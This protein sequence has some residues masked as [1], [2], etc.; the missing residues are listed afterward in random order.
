[1]HIV[2]H[3]GSLLVVPLL[4]IAGL[5]VI[6]IVLGPRAGAGRGRMWLGLGILIV[7]Q[8]LSPLWS[9]SIPFLAQSDP[10]SIGV[11][12][13]A[14][15]VVAGIAH[16]AAIAVLAS[17]ATVGRAPRTGYLDAS[18]PGAPPRHGYQG[19]GYPPDGGSPYLGRPGDGG[20]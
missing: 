11:L 12:S 4:I 10:A 20:A 17:A 7:L 8:A 9:L 19:T 5:V 2:S 6:G 13:T 16:V 3:Y 1:M 18:A 15:G 14:Y